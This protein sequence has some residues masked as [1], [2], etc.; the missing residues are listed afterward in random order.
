MKVAV[1]VPLFNETVNKF[2]KISLEQ[3]FRILSDYDIF[4]VTH[5][6]LNL[7]KY[8]EIINRKDIKNI[9][10]FE[11][12]YYHSTITYSHLLLS[13][14]FY[15]KFRDY[16]F[17]LIY[18]LDAFVFKDELSEW[19]AQEYDYV[20]APWFNTEI[21]SEFHKSLEISRNPF[22]KILKKSIN[23]NRKNKIDVGNG[24]FSLRKIESFYRISKW[25][26]F[27]EPNILNY[28]LNE[29]IVWSI[30]VPKYFKKFK[31]PE[32]KQALKFSIETEPDKAFKL[33]KNELPF[34]CHGWDKNNLEYWRPVFLDYGYKL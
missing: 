5:K 22:R 9:V 3:L 19:C 25:L 11:K 30:L 6:D 17:I 21:Q 24:G 34:G 27:I 8:F 33:L 29:D 28:D 26:P 32:L 15:R 10:Y 1:V 31:I 2:E 20:G 4:F 16:N 7:N 12:V 14:K 18:Q 23:F 13:S